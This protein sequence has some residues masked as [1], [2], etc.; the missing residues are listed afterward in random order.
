MFCVVRPQLRRKPLLPTFTK[1]STPPFAANAQKTRGEQTRRRYSKWTM[2]T[3]ILC[4]GTKTAYLLITDRTV[5]L[6]V[7]MK[8]N[9]SSWENNGSGRY[10]WESKVREHHQSPRNP[11]G[12]HGQQMDFLIIRMDRKVPLQRHPE[13]LVRA[14]LKRCLHRLQL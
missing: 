14:Y 9:N 4:F 1:L 10:T 6:M 12:R 8:R 2:E 13:L 11:R 7:S 3:T 5:M